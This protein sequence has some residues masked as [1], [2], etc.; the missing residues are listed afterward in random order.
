MI[1]KDPT[2]QVVILG[3][4]CLH[5]RLKHLDEGVSVLQVFDNDSCCAQRYRLG[6]R[7]NST[8]V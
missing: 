3:R 5:N 8:V 7:R 6:E 1:R 4:L 2:D